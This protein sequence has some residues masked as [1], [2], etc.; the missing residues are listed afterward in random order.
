MKVIPVPAL[1]Q[2]LAAVGLDGAPQGVTT[3]GVRPEAVPGIELGPCD[4]YAVTG[5]GSSRTAGSGGPRY[6]PS[7]ND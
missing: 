7:Q 4:V 5:R 1:Q 2:P 3:F 6:S